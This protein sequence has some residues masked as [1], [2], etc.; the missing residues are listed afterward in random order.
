[1]MFVLDRVLRGVF[2]KGALTIIAPSGRRYRYGDGQGKPIVARLRDDRTVLRLMIDP[3]VALGEAYMDE[4]LTFEEGTLYDFLDVA[5]ANLGWR[6]GTNWF[7]TLYY[8]YVRPALRRLEQYNPVGRSKSNVAHHYDLSDALYDRFLDGD[9]QYSC[10]YFAE[11]DDSIE[12]AQA[13]KKRHIAAKLLL[14]P[15]QRIL[16]IGCGWGGL[17]LYLSSIA[18]GDVTGVTL[19]EN[20]H[21]VASRRAM[22]AGVSD[23]VH[24]LLRDYR[25][26]ESKFD[27]IV[28]VGMFE[29]VGINHYAEYFRK[30][31]DLLTDDGVAL[32]HTIGRADGPGATNPWISKYIFPGGYS[33]A[34]SEI[35]PHIERAGLYITDIEILRL[36]YAETLKAWRQRFMA[37]VDE[38][39][40]IYDSRFCRMWEFYLAGSE[41]TF[42]HSG[43][44]VF[45]IQ[46]ARRQDA[47][48]LTRDYITEFEARH[49][50]APVVAEPRG[51]VDA[52][53]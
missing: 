43:H 25:L 18:G 33:P 12:T 38:I 45:Q 8:D 1:M 40:K 46:V 34:L 19:S 27:R 53:E 48:P 11:P 50:L 52:A 31:A 44:V 10:A 7:Q 20:Q 14:A 23:R 28:S 49:P 35:L 24:F 22:I 2:I 30:I 26:V 3:R 42:R 47:V 37:Q 39:A 9:R 32:V 21:A 51:L 41:V 17:G 5:T 16:D 29:H 13:R 6:N 15:G 36:H 4:G